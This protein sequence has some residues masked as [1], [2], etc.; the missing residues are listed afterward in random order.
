M[1]TTPPQPSTLGRDITNPL[2]VDVLILM[3]LSLLAL[4]AF[5]VTPEFAANLP[6]DGADFA[7][8]AV[9]LLERGQLVKSAFGYDFPLAHPVG[10]PLLLVPAYV[11]FGHALG[12]G[13]YAILL[14]ALGTIALTYY[15][16]LKLGGRWCG[17]FATLFLIT[18]YGFWQYSQKIMSEVPSA[19]LVMAVL[20]LLLSI[21][22]RKQPGLTCVAAGTVMAFA[23]SIRYDN[24]LAMGPAMLL[25]LWDGPWAQRFRRGV[26]LMLGL[27]PWL[28]SLAVYHQVQF[29]SPLRTGLNYYI[30]TKDAAHPVFSAKYIGTTSFLKTRGF[31]TRFAGMIEGNGPFYARSLLTE[32]DTTRVFGHPLYW[33]LPGRTTYQALVLFRTGLGALGLLVCLKV[34]R[35]NYLRRQFVLWLAA[36]TLVTVSFYL[37][38]FWQEE[39]YLVRFVPLFCVANGIGATELSTRCLAKAVRITWAVVF[40]MLIAAFAFYNWQMGFPN[41]NDSQL[42]ETLALAAQ[43]TDSNAVVVTNFEPFRLN[44]YLIQGTRRLAVPLA[45]NNAVAIFL[46]GSSTQTVVCPF[47]A[48]E[49]PERLGVFL[50][51][52]RPVYWLINNPWSGEPLVDLNALEKSFRLQV[53]ATASVNGN[54]VPYFGLIHKLAPKS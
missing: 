41:G 26:F 50:D 21:R 20:A 36:S 23:V 22:D 18:N 31:E 7:V 33:Q 15:L 9:N 49:N 16:G 28:V 10:M 11:F 13:V 54:D 5:Y 3:G 52:G 48:V 29:G 12:N 44:A 46:E 24:L 37:L 2:V 45:R 47:V 25:L 39:R 34:W 14:C 32:G 53:L 30:N 40:S 4:A 51:S 6:Q 19:F 1:N 38:Y 27:A 17:C 8:P 42:H 43:Q 35:S